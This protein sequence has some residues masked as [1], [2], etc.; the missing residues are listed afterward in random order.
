MLSSLTAALPRGRGAAPFAAAGFANAVGMGVYYPFALLF[1]QS[2]LHV[3]LSRIGVGLTAAALI[4]LPLM[5]WVGRRIDEFGPKRVL[6]VSTA[7][8]AAAFAAF[9]LVGSFPEFVGLSVLVALTMRTEQ[10]ASPV[11]ATVLAGDGPRG[12]W[13]ALS[14]AMFNAGF[15]L[16]ALAAG[17]VATATG[18]KL[19]AVGLANALC[20]AVTSLLYLA[21]PGG[22]TDPAD[23]PGART[24]KPW[25][26]G[27]FRAVV[28]AGAGLWIIAVGVET[29]LPV[30]L[31]HGL[32]MPPW[33]VSA[34]FAVNTLL[35][36]FCQVPVAHRLERYRPGALVAVGSVLH[37]ALL[38]ALAVAG[39]LGSAVRIPVLAVAMAVY[40]LGELITSQAVLT[41]LTSLAPEPHRGSYLAFNQ[42]FIGLANALAPLL[43]TVTLDRSAAALWWL[44]AACAVLI[45]VFARR[46]GQPDHD[47]QPDHDGRTGT[48]VDGPDQ[49]GEAARA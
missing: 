11:L 24:A 9:P 13:L 14:R 22:R 44:L 8:R 32:S 31:L 40:T 2:V 25:R 43:V 37:I 7:V 3:S 26:N 33:T 17:L 47:R 38:A 39:S 12:P 49:D 28:A 6:F 42:M 30:H 15:S 1:F 23:R 5:P 20:I 29:A 16:G 27:P 41:L 21:L 46:D 10:A 4:A 18:G 45:A 34:L 36:T 48:P 19:V 35:L